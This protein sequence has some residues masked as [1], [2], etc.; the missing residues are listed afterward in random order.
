VVRANT[1]KG[2][3]EAFAYEWMGEGS[4]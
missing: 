4:P 1:P 2:E 3:I